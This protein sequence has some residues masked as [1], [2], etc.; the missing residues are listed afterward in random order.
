MNT[1]SSEV[2][3]L[4][5]IFIEVKEAGAPWGIGAAQ[6]ILT[7]LRPAL[8]QTWFI[9]HVTWCEKDIMLNHEIRVIYTGV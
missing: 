1:S 2:L 3:I 8:K 9:V 4:P 6:R 7:R 5:F